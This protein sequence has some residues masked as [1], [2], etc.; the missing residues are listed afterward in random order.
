MLRATWNRS[1]RQNPTKQ[2]LYSHLPPIT[3]TIQLR[4]T[5]HAGHCFRSGNDLVSDVLLWTLSHGR[6]KAGR[7]ARTYLQQLCEDTGC[8]PE[9]LSEA[10]NDM[11]RW[12]E[13]VSYIRADG[14][15]RWWWYESRNIRAHS[16]ILFSFV[17]SS[18][19]RKYVKKLQLISKC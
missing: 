5:S 18:L 12:R 15:T 14:T 1:W 16:R 2:Q 8:S 17:S 13:R 7:P 6:T 3:K 11:E 9:D 4:R 19:K 10:M